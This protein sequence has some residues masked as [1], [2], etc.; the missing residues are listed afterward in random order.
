MKKIIV[1]I[2]LLCTT[3]ILYSQEKDAAKDAQNPLANIISMPLQNN[4]NFGLGDAD[5][6]SNTLNIQPIYPVAFSNKWVL[7]NRA[8]I[9]IETFPDFTQSSGSI[10]GLGDI[11]YTAWLSPPPSGGSFTWGFGF[12]SIW[13][14]ATDDILGSGKLSLGPSFVLVNMTEKLMLAAVISDWFSIAGDSEKADVNTFYLQ[15]I[16]TYFLANKWYLSS[17]PINTANWEAESDQRWTIPI[18]GGFGKMFKIGNLP[19]D[20][21]AQAFYY[22]VKPDGGPE[23]QLR[24]Q[25]KM[26]FPK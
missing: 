2:L 18:G 4:T 11:N 7:I 26:I 9:P 3:T 14:T 1:I 24:L 16:I 19:V 8:I 12:V 5:R 10:T 21:Q 22:V 6:T 23:W 15:Y 20:A 25:F 17:A 13:P